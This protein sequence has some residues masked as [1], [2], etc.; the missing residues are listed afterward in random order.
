M[1]AVLDELGKTPLPHH[2]ALEVLSAKALT[3]RDY[4][5]A[6]K[7]AD[8]RCRIDPPP[9][10]HCYVLRADASFN[11]GDV[12]AARAD[13]NDALRIAPDD[14]AALRRLFTWGSSEER[15]SAAIKLISA[16]TEMRLLRAAVELMFGNDQ[17]CHANLSI[18]DRV[19]RGW[20][21]WDAG[22]QVEFSIASNDQLITTAF[23]A[24]P[25]HALA[26]GE[27]KAT[28]FELARPSSASPQ[29]VSV[30]IDGRSFFSRRIAPNLTVVE[31]AQHQPALVPQDDGALPTVIIPVYDDFAATRACLNSL[32]ADA[33]CGRDFR[34]V[35]I[36]DA[37]PDGAIAQHLQILSRLPFVD[38]IVNEVNLGFVGSINRALESVPHGDVLL[39]NADTIVPP[40]FVDRLRQAAHSTSD[41][42]TVVPLSNNSGISDFPVPHH[43]N[44][45]GSYEDVVEI[46]SLAQSANSDLIIDL[47]NGTGFCL[48]I[49]RACIAAVGHLAE[50]F[51]RGYLEDIDFCLRGR[52][53]GF[54]NVCAPNVYVGHAGSRSFGEAKRTLVLKNLAVLDH[55]F[56]RFRAESSSFVKAD[57]L[58][59]ARINIER[60]RPT[61][62]AEERDQEMSKVSLPQVRKIGKRAEPGDVLAV[63]PA[64]PSPAEYALLRGLVGT[65]F[66]TQPQLDIVVAGKTFDD[67][68]LMSHPNVFISGVLEPHELG[69]VLSTVR[70]SRI[71]ILGLDSADDRHPALAIAHATDLPV[72]YVDWSGGTVP[73]RSG[74]LA[75]LPGMPR[76]WMIEQ[77]S[78]W[79][80]GA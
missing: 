11:L 7:L 39:L 15:Q 5:T 65:F 77:I 70:A 58:R 63:I 22:E 37:S 17:R 26:T 20:V 53:K 54:R 23:A 55:R 59:P 10:A 41:I 27:I 45:L 4:L 34:I 61:L 3:A 64:R 24:D 12:D 51:E 73:V 52:E 13:L 18:F 42:G 62:A 29:T 74:D 75:I 46:D 76:P 2:Q 19:I 36:D 6:F 66:R 14:L 38:L 1:Q 30:A 21:V 8:R 9:L 79:V 43:A 67:A 57:P 35:L 28:S 68:R 50:A 47:P 80:K 32:L 78:A 69:R 60:L 49:T 40:G 72:G 48:Y 25:F 33:G 71:L 56:P 31:A 16:E 44:A